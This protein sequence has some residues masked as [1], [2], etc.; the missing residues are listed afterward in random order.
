MKTIEVKALS[1]SSIVVSGFGSRDIAMKVTTRSPVWSHAERGWVLM[2]S[3]LAD[4]VAVAEARGYTVLLD[5]ELSST[6]TGRPACRSSS[7]GGQPAITLEVEVGELRD[8]GLD[9]HQGDIGAQLW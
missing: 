5:A 9:V 6:P 8:V 3:R 4:L 7:D 2:T 1:R